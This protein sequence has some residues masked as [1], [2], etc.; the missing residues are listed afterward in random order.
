MEAAL[1]TGRRCIGAE[2]SAEWCEKSRLRAM[3]A[4]MQTID[5]ATQP[6]LFGDVK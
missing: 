5:G 6:S 1:V 4:T 2:Q 3:S